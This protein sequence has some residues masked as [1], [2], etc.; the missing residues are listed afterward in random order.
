MGT[1][2]PL[3]LQKR[4][5]TLPLREQGQRTLRKQGLSKVPRVSGMLSRCRVPLNI[6][7]QTRNQEDHSFNE[8]KRRKN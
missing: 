3:H 8:Q 6:T 2:E 1:P 5:G 4:G 7:L